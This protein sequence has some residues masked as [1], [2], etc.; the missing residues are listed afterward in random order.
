MK[1]SKFVYSALLSIACLAFAQTGGMTAPN[2]VQVNGG[3]LPTNSPVVG[4]NNTGQLTSTNAAGVAGLFGGS[5]GCPFL[6]YSGGCSA[7]SAATQRGV[8]AVVVGGLS[9]GATDNSSTMLTMFSTYCAS[10]SCEIYVPCGNY[11]V[12]HTPTVPFTASAYG[13][14]R[15]I[16]EG[17][18]SYGPTSHTCVNF[19][20]NAANIFGLW[21]DNNTANNN[22]NNAGIEIDNIAFTDTN[23]NASGGLRITQINSGILRDVSF[24]SFNGTLATAGGTITVTNG[25][26]TATCSAC[27]TNSNMQFGQLF[28]KGVAQEIQSVSGTTITLSIPWQYPSCSACAVGTWG[29][30]YNG[31][32]LLMEGSS[33]ATF[34][35][36]QY[37]DI[38]DIYA[39]SDR[40]AVDMGGGP[41]SSFG[42]S[43]V[44]IR[45]G[46]INCEHTNDSIGLWAGAFSDTIEYNVPQN[47]CA[48][49]A[50]LENSH[51]DKIEPQFE[52]DVNTTV[53]TC[54][55]SGKAC[56][57]GIQFN[58]YNDCQINDF[59]GGYIYGMGTGIN[60]EDNSSIIRTQI[61]GVRMGNNSNN[62]TWAS[63]ATCNTQTSATIVQPDCMAMQA[64]SGSINGI[65]WSTGSGAPSGSC[66]TGSIYSNKTGGA[67][68]SLYGC[69]SGAW[70]DIL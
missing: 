68:T 21:L 46:E 60:F 12:T 35:F 6:T 25:S 38:E 23:G 63:G 67:G 56:N 49:H 8:D 65:L 39:Y 11:N 34:A 27:T 26:T 70:A 10:T 50:Y 66:T 20:V 3:T 2:T 32:G 33:V 58:C 4:T 48:F 45:G 52:N 30:D 18:A 54:T 9:T 31:A 61:M 53:P 41:S 7:S 24:T 44:K 42:V 59:F 5:A 15:I 17:H 36:T 19:N 40:I 13:G 28:V 1:L 55:G 16:G 29:I 64:T 69:K 37:W 51:A 62:Y 57:F 22:G 47:N 43:R 14:L